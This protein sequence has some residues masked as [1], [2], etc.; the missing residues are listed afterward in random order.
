MESW[1]LV[2]R[3]GFAPCLSTTGLMALREALIQDDHRLTQGTTT[4]PPPMMCVSEWPVEGACALGYC[5]WQGE[6]LTTVTEVEEFFARTCYEA[7]VRMG[8][9]AGCRY[10]LNWFDDTPRAEMLRDLL[11]EVERTLSERITGEPNP[12]AVKSSTTTEPAPKRVASKRK[13]K[14]KSG[15]DVAA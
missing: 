1:K 4:T 11:E 12:D 6:G 9:P 7:D 3:K 14:K 2:W 8:E 10:F 13:S 15:N 5:G